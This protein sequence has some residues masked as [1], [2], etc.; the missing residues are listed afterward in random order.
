MMSDLLDKDS[1]NAQRAAELEQQVATLSAEIGVR[2]SVVVNFLRILGEAEIPID[3]LGPKLEEIARR[4]LELLERWSVLEE[5]D[6]PMIRAFTDAAKAAIDV[7]DYERADTLL[8]E[9]EGQDLAVARQ[10]QALAAQAPAAANRRFLSAAAKRAKR[11]ELRLIQFDHIGAAGHFEAAAELVPTGESLVLAGY[12]MRA[13]SALRDATRY[14]QGQSLV[15]RALGI[16]EE[17][18]GPEQPEV[19]VSLNDLA[20]LYFYQARLS[21]AEPLMR[22][23]LAINEV[24]YGAEHPDLAIDLYNLAHL[25]KATNRLAEAEPLMERAVRILEVSY[26]EG[27]PNMVT[28]LNNLSLLLQAT[29]R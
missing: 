22:R 25:L 9:A 13:G 15:E 24:S 7:G 29:N 16:R 21:E 2:E 5:D 4:H 23:A 14:A 6:D 27:R 8:A 20:L 17:V 12:L 10:A 26:G 18:L 28:V 19:A 3:D 1:L 11:G